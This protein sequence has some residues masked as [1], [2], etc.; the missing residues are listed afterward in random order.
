MK[1]LV[2]LVG[3]EVHIMSEEKCM[4]VSM[5]CNI[6]IACLHVHCHHKDISIG[7]AHN[8]FVCYQPS[9]KPLY[10]IRRILEVVVVLL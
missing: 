2:N 6:A 5:H 4:H 3:V 9:Q 7:K 8:G 10:T 1:I